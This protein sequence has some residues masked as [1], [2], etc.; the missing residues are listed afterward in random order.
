MVLYDLYYR[1]S[2]DSIELRKN[3]IPFL[4]VRVPQPLCNGKA[5]SYEW[6]L[7]ISST[8]VIVKFTGSVAQWVH[9]I[10]DI[11]DQ[12]SIKLCTA[13]DLLPN[14]WTRGEFIFVIIAAGIFLCGTS[15]FIGYGTAVNAFNKNPTLE[16]FSPG[17]RRYLEQQ[18]R[19]PKRFEKL[20]AGM[21][22]QNGDTLCTG[23]QCLLLEQCKLVHGKRVMFYWSHYVSNNC[24]LT[25]QED[26]NLVLYSNT[27]E[28]YVAS[29]TAKTPCHSVTFS[30][31]ALKL[32]CKYT[33]YQW[34]SEL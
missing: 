31:D 7:D 16:I 17:I 22:M 8:T 25:M 23:D 19:A 26:G 2:E 11:K 10:K 14:Q 13:P 21:S 24:K 6:E 32:H 5:N 9:S 27:G 18:Q 34:Y 28:P 12:K 20:T 1:V 29:D 4:S 15:L 3:E 33:S 30:D